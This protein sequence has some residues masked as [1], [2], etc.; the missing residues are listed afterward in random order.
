LEDPS[1]F[2]MEKNLIPTRASIATEKEKNE[3]FLS[4]EVVKVIP[5]V[6]NLWGHALHVILSII[7][8]GLFALIFIWNKKLWINVRFTEVDIQKADYVIVIT[9]HKEEILLEVWE[10]TTFGTPLR[11]LVYRHLKYYLSPNGEFIAV[12]ASFEGLTQGEFLS[13]CSGGI[14][15]ELIPTL[16]R[17]Y[18]KNSTLIKIDTI[19]KLLI[20]EVLTSFNIYQ[21]FACFVWIFFRQQLWVGLSI[22]FT[23]MIVISTKYHLTRTE[24]RRCNNSTTMPTYKVQRRS[25]PHLKTTHTENL[26]SEELLPGDLVTIRAESTIPAD[27][28]LVDGFCRT[29]ESLLSGEACP[30]LKTAVNYV[31]V[32]QQPFETQGLVEKSR[33]SYTDA[34]LQG[35]ITDANIVYAGSWCVSADNPRGTSYSARGVVFATGFGTK[36]GLILRKSLGWRSYLPLHKD[37]NSLIY[38]ISTF[39]AGISFFAIIILLKEKVTIYDLAIELLWI[40]SFAVLPVYGVIL[41]VVDLSYHRRFKTHNIA[42]T[43][44]PQMISSNSLGSII[45]EKTGVLTSK[46]ELLHSVYF[47][48]HINP[49]LMRF[50]KLGGYINEVQDL[51]LNNFTSNNA[52]LSLPIDSNFIGDPAEK[53]LMNFAQEV[54]AS[55]KYEV[56]YRFPYS[57]ELKTTSAVVRNTTNSLKFL[58][59]KGKPDVIASI[60]AESS[61]PKRMTRDLERYCEEGHRVEAYAFKRLIGNYPPMQIAGVS[62]SQ[63]SK[64]ATE[65]YQFHFRRAAEERDLSFQG[66]ALF[67]NRARVGGERMLAK[68]YKE[69]QG[70]QDQDAEDRKGIYI[71]SNDI[72]EACVHTA[73]SI[74]LVKENKEVVK[75]IMFNYSL[76]QFEAVSKQGENDSSSSKNS[77]HR[78]NNL[79]QSLKGSRSPSGHSPIITEQKVASFN[80]KSTFAMGPGSVNEFYNFASTY[81]YDI[82]PELTSQFESIKIFYDVGFSEKNKIVEIFTR[83]NERDNKNTLYVCHTPVPASKYTLQMATVKGATPA[84]GVMYNH[85]L[86]DIIL[87]IREGKSWYNKRG[88][89]VNYILTLSLLGMIGFFIC[90]FRL[91][92]D[93]D[94]E[95]ILV[96]FILMSFFVPIVLTMFSCHCN[97]TSNSHWLNLITE[98]LLFYFVVHAL[99]HV[100][101]GNSAAPFE[102]LLD[103]KQISQVMEEIVCLMLAHA[104]SH[105]A[106]QLSTVRLDYLC[107]LLPAILTLGLSYL[108]YYLLFEYFTHSISEHEHNTTLLLQHNWMVLFIYSS[109]SI[110][111]R[112]LICAIFT[113]EEKKEAL[114]T[115]EDVYSAHSQHGNR[116]TTHYFESNVGGQGST[117]SQLQNTP[118]LAN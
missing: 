18:G 90:N 22:L 102:L 75:K 71:V 8:L 74:G 73:K 33:L 114:Q 47:S 34:G 110:C 7:T 28:I 43:K 69:L 115:L 10:E 68:V 19:F 2:V 105:L 45:F 25:S 27:I 48:D 15:A 32:M 118:L 117:P 92:D 51:L 106:P 3:F 29:D 62:A 63:S 11:L 23:T 26:E 113:R 49:G 35:A 87:A 52:L 111:T 70:H 20:E 101:P 24:Q 39:L 108:A 16:Q 31:Q 5:V 38:S 55:Q 58:L 21:F 100:H 97:N 109:L 80:L 9:E 60:C 6:R 57:V 14:S 112:I 95:I 98:P 78:S 36:R 99:Y 50:D 88:D 66:I 116:G 67:E 4:N 13:T 54:G 104:C 61:V 89:T 93:N 1:V 82:T 42:I 84:S 46:G 40:M 76:G 86:D 94:L 56:L 53:E 44:S 17:L 30:V 59:I 107:S 65:F 81:N 37:T 72:F 91:R 12:R 79:F 77:I 64:S 83:L 96:Y 103:Y 41:S 85:S